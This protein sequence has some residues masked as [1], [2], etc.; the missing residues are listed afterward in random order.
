[1]NNDYVIFHVDQHT[2]L[3][4]AEN[5]GISLIVIQRSGCFLSK[6]CKIIGN[7]LPAATSSNVADEFHLHRERRIEEIT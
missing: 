2:A 4:V 1:M 6:F 3:F 7:L 5:I